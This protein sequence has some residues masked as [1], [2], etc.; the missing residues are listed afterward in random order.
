MLAAA[1]LPALLSLAQAE[2]VLLKPGTAL[3]PPVGIATG[4]PHVPECCSE[5]EG[6]VAVRLLR[7]EGDRL[8]VETLGEKP[9]E[10]V[11][12]G[13]NAFDHGAY[14]HQ[15]SSYRLR[16]WVNRE[17]AMRVTAR[18]IELRFDDGTEVTLGP[19]LPVHTEGPERNRVR[20]GFLRST[21]PFTLL[22]EE[23]ALAPSY[24]L[25]APMPEPAEECA[26]SENEWWTL[27]RAA[28]ATMGR[29]GTLPLNAREQWP[30]CAVRFDGR[31]G[32]L[33]PVWWGCASLRA[34]VPA[35]ALRRATRVPG[36][37]HGGG[38]LCG[39]AGPI[40][41]RS[42]AKA[43]WPNGEVAGTTSGDYLDLPFQERKGRRCFD[44][45]LQ[46]IGSSL[47]LCFDPA[48]LSRRD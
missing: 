25:A 21:R 22:L 35:K 36:Y 46:N 13:F 48:D 42:G 47:P 44:V 40:E 20:F 24:R 33:V 5:S 2:Y 28:T 37:G 17:A 19:G 38:T 26:S 39:H 9:D 10:R 4:K 30:T 27:P 15:L 32:A 7:A 31:G 1:S 11:H 8:E 41:V 43:F 16:V 3:L 18:P 23:G 14:S 12:C 6:M 34:K 45:T 29:A